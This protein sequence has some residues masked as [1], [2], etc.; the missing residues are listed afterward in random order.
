MN[1]V[2]L[3]PNRSTQLTPALPEPRGLGAPTSGVPSTQGPDLDNPFSVHSRAAASLPQNRF[4]AP[5]QRERILNQI[6]RFE[7][8]V[9]SMAAQGAQGRLGQLRQ[10]LEANDLL[11][12]APIALWAVASHFEPETLQAHVS[13]R[14]GRVHIFL[15]DSAGRWVERPD[16]AAKWNDGHIP[17]AD[18]GRLR[19]GG[20]AALAKATLDVN[21]NLSISLCDLSRL[22]HSPRVRPFNIGDQVQVTLATG[23]VETRTQRELF[24]PSSTVAFGRL[25]AQDGRG[26]WTVELTE[27]D[28]SPRQAQP[29][30]LVLSD[31]QLRRH[32]NPNVLRDGDRVYD[33]RFDSQDPAQQSMI[34]SWR[35]SAEYRALVG[36]EAKLGQARAE[37]EERAIEAADAWLDGRMRY[38]AASLEHQ[39]T[40]RGRVLEITSELETATGERRLA[41]E[42][43][44]DSLEHVLDR[45]EADADLALGFETRL[46]RS[47]DPD[48]VQALKV[49]LA[50]VRSRISAD[51]RYHELVARP[52]A[53]SIG[54]YFLNGTGECRHQ[55]L[56]LHV[57]LQDLGVDSRMTRGV[58]NDDTG[59]YRGDH[60]WLEVSLSDGRQLIVDPTWTPHAPIDDLQKTYEGSPRRIETPTMTESDFGPSVVDGRRIGVLAASIQA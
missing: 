4:D 55:A 52:V 57:I 39:A 16:L 28:G 10:A 56:A 3:S 14:G 17:S 8:A 11:S 37:F 7:R 51:H 50:E 26:T 15:E 22:D 30:T 54:E 48:E 47:R 43:E 5:W 25:T 6:D 1:S 45:S 34:E 46:E 59:R 35:N 23:D 49:Q 27:P 33:A 36:Q 32:N 38:P 44:R 21:G 42:E 2:A 13:D 18:P 60:M 20:T 19:D 29:T 12:H 31:A 58:A 40:A 53:P 9:T 41:L 24:V